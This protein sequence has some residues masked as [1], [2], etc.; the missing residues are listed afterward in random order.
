M[1]AEVRNGALGLLLLATFGANSSIGRDQTLPNFEFLPE[2][3]RSVP[4]EAFS[5]SAVFGDG[6]TMRPPVAG[7]IP[8]GWM[9]LHY[10]ATEEDALRAGVELVNPFSPDDAAALARGARVYAAWCQVCHGGGG[11]GDGPVTRRGVPPPPSLLAE[12]ALEMPD[13]Q[14][15]HVSTYGQNNMAAYA[16]QVSREDRWKA[17]LHIRSLQ[18]QAP[19]PPVP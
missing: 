14:M 15:F 2:M 11:L 18:E 17:I 12:H 8:R 9:P 13:G 10:E 16:A 1:T 3:V 19:A 6:V 5:E 7:T 4:A